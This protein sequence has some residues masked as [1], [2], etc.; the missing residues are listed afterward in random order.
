MLAVHIKPRYLD[1]IAEE[2]A[3]LGL[4]ALEICR[5]GVTYEF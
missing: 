3:S 2:L 4:P 5:P 1:K